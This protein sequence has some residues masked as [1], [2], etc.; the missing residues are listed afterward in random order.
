V[1]ARL[2]HGGAIN[3]SARGLVTL[4]LW[5]AGQTELLS[6]SLPELPVIEVLPFRLYGLE[7]WLLVVGVAL[8]SAPW[9]RRSRPAAPSLAQIS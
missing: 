2:T 9:E 1:R 3:G 8:V 4:P 6:L 7:L 5:V